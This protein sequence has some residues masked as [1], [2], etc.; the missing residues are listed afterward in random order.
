KIIKNRLTGDLRA[1]DKSAVRVTYAPKSKRLYD[2]A[3]KSERVYGW[4]RMA[5]RQQTDDSPGDLPF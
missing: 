1:T 2:V 4:A 5:L 3:M